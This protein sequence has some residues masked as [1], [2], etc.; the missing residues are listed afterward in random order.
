MMPG[1]LLRCKNKGFAEEAG[2]TPPCPAALIS[3]QHSSECVCVSIEACRSMCAQG[4]SEE[5]VIEFAYVFVC[6]GHLLWFVLGRC[7][8]QTAGTGTDQVWLSRETKDIFEER[9][10]A[11]SPVS[12]SLTLFFF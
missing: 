10:H 8:S 9:S 11:C 6:V 12:S 1:L 7:S 2:R 4:S 5:L 3:F